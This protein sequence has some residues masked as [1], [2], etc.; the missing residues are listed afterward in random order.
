MF[1]QHPLRTTESGLSIQP[2]LR[3]SLRTS[4]V[5]FADVL[6]GRRVIVAL[7]VGIDDAHTKAI[8]PNFE[9]WF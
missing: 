2:L 8:V 9:L 6:P 5:D 4:G 1:C 3:I 7:T